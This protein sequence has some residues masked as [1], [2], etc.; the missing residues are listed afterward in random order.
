MTSTRQSRV[1]QTLSN[2]KKMAIAS[3]LRKTNVLFIK[4]GP[5]LA[6]SFFVPQN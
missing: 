6:E 5:K 3:I 4:L 2:K 1:G